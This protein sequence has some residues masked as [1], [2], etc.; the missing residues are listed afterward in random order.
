MICPNFTQPIVFEPLFMERIWGSRRLEMQFGK[1]LPPERECA[2]ANRGRLSTALKRKALCATVHCVVE[3]CMNSGH[4]VAAQYLL[5]PATA[6]WW[7]DRYQKFREHLEARYPV[8]MRDEHT[9]I[10]FHLRQ[11]STQ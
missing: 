8:I 2:S 11:S 5:L 10:I 7:F 4:K 3:R 6:F 9:C 1:R